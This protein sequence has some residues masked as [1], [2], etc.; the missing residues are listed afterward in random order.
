MTGRLREFSCLAIVLCLTSCAKMVPLASVDNFGFIDAPLTKE[1]MKEAIEEGATNA[2]W[3]AKAVKGDRIIASY[4]PRSHRVVVEITY[5]DDSYEIRYKAS[6][7]MKIYCSD[8]ARDAG[9][10]PKLTGTESCPG[11]ADPLYIHHAYQ[12]WIDNL[13]SS[14]DLS[15][16]YAE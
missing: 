6:S 5:T 14:I 12:L 16:V 10:K 13:K 9:Q 1:K 4:Q 7:R 8:Q 2:G 11:N 15:L 3:N